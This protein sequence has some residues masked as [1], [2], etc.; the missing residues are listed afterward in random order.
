MDNPL[1]KNITMTKEAILDRILS[2]LEKA[3][4]SGDSEVKVPVIKQFQEE[5]KVAIEWLYPVEQDDL[6]GERMDREEVRKMVDSLNTSIKAGKLKSA[7]DHVVYT[8]GW[9]IE[10][11][12][13]NEAECSIN[14]TIIP[15]GWPLCK[16][17]FT[18]DA[19]WQARKEGKLQGLSIGA[20][21]RKEEVE[22]D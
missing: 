14:G 17:K 10:K 1:N 5:E 22:I 2:V 4:G 21:G 19:L 9:H 3:L 7:I 11:A 6:H 8:D 20:K 18:N 16:V 12:W 13:V 15:E